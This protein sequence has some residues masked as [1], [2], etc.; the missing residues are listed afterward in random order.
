VLVATDSPASSGPQNQYLWGRTSGVICIGA[1][2][3]ALGV[4]AYLLFHKGADSAPVA[5]VSHDGAVVGWA[6]RF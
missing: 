6:G 4:G 1:G 2:A 5:A 3:V